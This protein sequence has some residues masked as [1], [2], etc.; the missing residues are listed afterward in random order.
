MNPPI[1]IT[2]IESEKIKLKCECHVNYMLEDDHR[3]RHI[4]WQKSN[5]ASLN[6]Y[7]Y[8]YYTYLHPKSFTIL[9][10]RLTGEEEKHSLVELAIRPGNLMWIFF[11]LL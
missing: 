11:Y 8:L 9:E 6:R 2:M 4:R 5:T 10:V 7:N 3:R 1:T